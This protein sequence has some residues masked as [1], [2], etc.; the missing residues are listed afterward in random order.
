MVAQK[1][2]SLSSSPSLSLCSSLSRLRVCMP[3]FF[4]LCVLCLP[5]GHPA[6]PPLRLPLPPNLPPHDPPHTHTPLIDR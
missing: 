6:F 1:P 3:P 5:A 2:L 4:F